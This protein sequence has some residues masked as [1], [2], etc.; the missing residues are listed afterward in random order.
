MRLLATLT[1]KSLGEKENVVFKKKKDGCDLG[2]GNSSTE[3]LATDETWLF[4][5]DSEGKRE[6][7][8]WETPGASPSKK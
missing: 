5:Y 4:Y 2:R 8:V 7:S 1:F 6:S 3:L